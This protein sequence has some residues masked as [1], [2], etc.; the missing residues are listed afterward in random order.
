[1]IG[2]KPGDPLFKTIRDSSP[3]FVEDL[4]ESD[5]ADLDSSHIDLIKRHNLRSA[6]FIPIRGHAGIR[7]ILALYRRLARG[8]T[9]TDQP[10][11]KELTERIA[12]GVRNVELY[13]KSENANRAKDEFLAVISH[14]LRTPLV[15]IVGWAS[16]LV[17]KELSPDAKQKG[18]QTILR[19]ANSQ[20]DLIN[21]ILDFSKIA[22]GT[23][24]MTFNTVDATTIL[25][26]TIESFRLAW[27]AELW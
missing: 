1:V 12:L 8:F 7:A 22:A 11:A 15:S 24:S 4:A 6:L 3:K 21:E 10:F 13:Q 26:Q 23:F 25:E 27:Q 16:L 20:T 5:Y 17:S 14:E 19:N 18:L 2:Y 9:G